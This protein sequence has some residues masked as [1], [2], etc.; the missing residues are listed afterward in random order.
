LDKEC[1]KYTFDQIKVVCAMNN[2]RKTSVASTIVGG[3]Q[4]NKDMWVA[5]E[6]TKHRLESK[7]GGMLHHKAQK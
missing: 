5:Q 6:N 3:L 2:V 7:H 4:E 1:A